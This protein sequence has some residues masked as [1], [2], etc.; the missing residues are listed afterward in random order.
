MSQTDSCLLLHTAHRLSTGQV[1]I[2]CRILFVLSP[3]F[4]FS[5]Y[6]SLFNRG[7][8]HLPTSYKGISHNTVSY[9]GIP[10]NTIAYKG[11]REENLSR[12]RPS[13]RSTRRNTQVML[14]LVACLLNPFL[15]LTGKFSVSVE[16]VLGVFSSCERHSELAEQVYILWRPI[17][18]GDYLRRW[19]FYRL[20]NRQ[21]LAGQST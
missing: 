13:K 21:K 8:S 7:V 10:H 20:G 14:L 17:P 6:T 16:T 9:Q 18:K 12:R 3:T 15:M 2:C 1:R 19:C 4:F 11:K 5:S